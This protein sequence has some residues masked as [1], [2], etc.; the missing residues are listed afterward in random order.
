MPRTKR[1]KWRVKVPIK[2]DRQ[3]FAK[4]HFFTRLIDYAIQK[5]VK[6][7]TDAR[8]GEPVVRSI[9]Q[10]ARLL[11][12]S[13]DN[14]Y[15]LV[16]LGLLRPLKLGAMM[17][18]LSEIDRFVTD[19]LGKDL[20]EVIEDEKERNREQRSSEQRNRVVGMR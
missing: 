12:T 16:K 9:P 2:I 18:P 14:V 20:R 15:A 8:Q 19:N 17:V 5:Y 4:E 3:Q 11:K 6:A 1:I 13:T 7:S 10:T